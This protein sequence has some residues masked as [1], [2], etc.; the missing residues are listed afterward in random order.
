MIA[1]AVVVTVAVVPWASRERTARCCGP[2]PD[3][4]ADR[5]G[6]QSPRGVPL[7]V[8]RRARAD[9][10][11]FRVSG[12]GT[13]PE[14]ASA[15]P[16][17]TRTTG[18]STAHRATRVRASSACRRPATP[19]TA[20]PSR[21]RSRSPISTGS[22]CRP[23]AR[24]PR[25]ATF[26]GDRR[27]A[28]ADRFYYQRR[29]RSR[30]ADLRRGSAGGGPLRALGCGARSGRSRD[31]DTPGS[32]AGGVRRR[33]PEEVGRR[34][35]DRIRRCSPAGPRPAAP[36][37]RVPQSQPRLG[38]HRGSRVDRRPPRLSAAAERVRSL[39]RAH[40]PHVRAAAR[41][42]DDPRAEATGN[43]V[44]AVGDDEQFAV[45]T[46]LIARELGFPARVVVGARLETADATL[47]TCDAGEC[48]P[49][50]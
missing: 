35:R 38:G 13:L 14:R 10:V 8:L 47:S 28:L 29:A 39:P 43:Y 50:T 37:A 17:S 44:A 30:S 46:A 18:R 21:S 19:A 11:L 25:S 45:A 3:R 32:A 2:P 4:R 16:P 5:R 22:G 24:P 34:A 20:G 40:R 26:E 12:E 7:H 48:R 36:G 42:R 23:P 9:Q 1:L 49:R 27:G 15:S 6:G 41:P 31:P 33:Q